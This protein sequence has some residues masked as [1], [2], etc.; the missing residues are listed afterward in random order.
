MNEQDRTNLISNLAGHLGGAKKH[1]QEAQIANFTKADAD[2]GRR[3]TEKI[4]ELE[5]QGAFKSDDDEKEG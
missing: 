2:W 4:A 3:L 1:I 5:K